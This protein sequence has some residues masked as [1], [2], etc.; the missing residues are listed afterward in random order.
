VDNAGPTSSPG[1]RTPDAPG[2][3]VP[4]GDSTGLPPGYVWVYQAPPEPE[5]P[6]KPSRWVIGLTVAWAL[7]LVVSGTF[8]ALH[9]KPTVRE[10]TTIADARGTVDRA[11]AAVVTAAGT[12][13]VISIGPFAEEKTCD[14]TPVRSGQSWSRKI[15]VYDGPGGE[16]PLLYTIADGLPSSYHAKAGPG[17]ILNLDADAGD[18]VGVIG[19]VPSPGDIEFRIAT[20]CRP[21]GGTIPAAPGP[22]TAE[23]APVTALLD[24]LGFKASTTAAAQVPCGSGGVIRTVSAHVNGVPQRSLKTELPDLA[25]DARTAT[26]SILAYHAAGGVDMVITQDSDGLTV[27]ATTRC[28]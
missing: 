22:T 21:P 19:A 27:A 24:G 6:R 20:G 26:D 3:P 25:V 8:Y 9:G 28:R 11:S 2:P 4:A 13:P 16:S 10:Q 14:I 17:H 15:N 5:K 1:A 7:I 18:Y 12:G 23:L